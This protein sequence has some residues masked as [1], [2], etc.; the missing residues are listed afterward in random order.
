M[1]EG[2]KIALAILVDEAYSF[3]LPDNIGAKIDFFDL[4]AIFVYGKLG[5]GWST[6]AGPDDE[7]QFIYLK[8][9]PTVEPPSS[10]SFTQLTA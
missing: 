4:E 6:E 1:H 7:L 5:R 3:N 8:P 9:K 10:R 2:E